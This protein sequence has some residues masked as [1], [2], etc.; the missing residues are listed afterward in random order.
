MLKIPMVWSVNPGRQVA[1]MTPVLIV[2]IFHL[3][4]E[5]LRF[6]KS[7]SLIERNKSLVISIL[8]IIWKNKV[9]KLGFLT[10][11]NY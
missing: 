7:T 6:E 10:Y 11:K 3:F 1:R 8:E 2:V 9:D 5:R 4:P